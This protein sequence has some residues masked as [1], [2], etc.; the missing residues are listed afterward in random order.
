M[1]SH[2]GYKEYVVYRAPMY[3]YHLRVLSLM[4]SIKSDRET[5]HEHKYHHRPTQ[6]CRV[7]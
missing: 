7:T 2:P 3:C 6:G 1:S 5:A 4:R